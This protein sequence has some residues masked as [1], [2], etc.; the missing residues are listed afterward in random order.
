MEDTWANRDLPVLQAVVQ[1][2]EET[3]RHLTRARDIARK[4]GFD[5]DTTQRAL[6]ALQTVP[7]FEK[8]PTAMGGQV[9]AVGPP[10]GTAYQVAG[11]WPT[12]ESM[13][14]RLIAAFEAAANDEQLDEPE[15]T[16]ARKIL[17]G[18]LSGGSKI[19]IAALGS[20]GGHALY[21]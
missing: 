18:L 5:E 21:S 10:I 14:E 4:T 20:A 3:G 8:G 16:R 9:I 6:R 15:R 7:F 17:D 13:V 19:A 1:I 2:Y 11:A 12:P